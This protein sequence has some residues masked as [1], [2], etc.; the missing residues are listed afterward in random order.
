[1]RVRIGWTLGLLLL[2]VLGGTGRALAFPGPGRLGLGLAV[3]GLDD[4]LP[5]TDDLGRNLGL[6]IEAITFDFQTLGNLCRHHLITSLHIMEPH[7]IEQVGHRRKELVPQ[8]HQERLLAEI[9]DAIDYLSLPLDDWL[10]EGRIIL[11]IILEIR[12]LNDYRIARHRLE[13]SAN[14][15][16]LAPIHR[17]ANNLKPRDIDPLEDASRPIAGAIIDDDDFLFNIHGSHTPQDR[18]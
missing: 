18:L 12:I 9:P 16:P 7:T 10:Q 1:M 2:F 15:C 8:T 5:H 11:G 13:G 6:Q 17:V 4:A 14:S 3:G